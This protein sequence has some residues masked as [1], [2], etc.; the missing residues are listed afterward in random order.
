MTN[1]IDEYKKGYMAKPVKG[2][3]NK[4]LAICKDPERLHLTLEGLF[5]L[6]SE[7]GLEEVAGMLIEDLAEQGDDGKDI[8]SAALRIAIENGYTDI[9]ELL[10]QHGAQ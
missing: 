10:K 9:V 2:L 5:L 3:L 8:M 1:I 7:H 4:L 6:V